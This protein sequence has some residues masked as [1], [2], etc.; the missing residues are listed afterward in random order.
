[1]IPLISDQQIFQGCLAKPVASKLEQVSQNVLDFIIREDRIR[2]H[3]RFYM[4]FS[5]KAEELVVSHQ[6]KVTGISEIGW[7]RF[8]AIDD[9][10][11]PWIQLRMLS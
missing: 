10:L 5:D 9:L 4:P 3:A 8:Q 11:G 6:F 1:M 7:F 2:K